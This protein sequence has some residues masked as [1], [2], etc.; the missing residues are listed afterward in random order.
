MPMMS[1]LDGRLRI[2]GTLREQMVR[3]TSANLTEA[4]QVDDSPVPTSDVPVSRARG[5][6]EQL[7]V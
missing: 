7:W 1:A 5:D 3:S 2:D 4:S 6:V